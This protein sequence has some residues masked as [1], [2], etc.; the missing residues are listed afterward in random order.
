MEQRS[1][2]LRAR[3]N[4]GNKTKIIPRDIS[5][6]LGKLP[7]QA[8]DI[9]E[10]ILGAMML[11]QNALIEIIDI[12]KPHNFY[13]EAHKL[14]YEAI[15]VLNNESA[16]IDMRTVVHKLREM[17]KLELVGGAFKIAELTSKVSSATNIMYHARIVQEFSIKRSL[18]ELASQVHHNAYEDNQ[19]VL[20]L[21]DSTQKWFD[22]ISANYFKGNFKTAAQLHAE[23][24]K[25]IAE[26]KSSNGMV[27]VMSGFVALDLITY[28]FQ[29]GELTVI[30][31][32]PGMGKTATV[33]CMARNIAIGSNMPVAIFS[34]EMVAGQI[35]KRMIS[36]ESE[37]ALER[38]I[39]GQTSPAEEEKIN[40]TDKV[41]SEAKIY[42]D[43]NPMLNILEFR[44]R[45]RRLVM[46]HKVKAIIVDYLQLMKDPEA[47]N[48]EQEIANISRHLKIVAKELNIPVIALAQ[49][50]RAVETRGGT[51]RPQLSDLRESGG[52]EQDADVVAFLYRPE[53][54]KIKFYEDNSSTDGVMEI[55]IAKHRNGKLDTAK[56]NYIGHFTKVK[57]FFYDPDPDKN[58]Q[59]AQIMVGKLHNK[60][61]AT[62][63]DDLPF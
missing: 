2:S 39:R 20:E 11:E 18:I 63:D 44:A 60:Q 42:I 9:E 10:A 30:A 37:V 50:S 53:Y 4:A 1:T 16:P 8:P 51:K 48:R 7:P 34:L 38:I 32:R 33:V 28:G 49:L 13:S 3:G 40:S 5:E 56:V 14:I 27:G 23:Q 36:S 12:L 26:R 35:M 62:T 55:I 45:S 47:F 29:N 43:D 25:E 6:S 24:K 54:Y 31:A 59:A 52:I 46:Q 15:L 57:D 61:A 21:M 41:L 22:N 17:G 19:D 58:T